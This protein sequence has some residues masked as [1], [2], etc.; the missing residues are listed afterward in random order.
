MTKIKG[1]LGFRDLHGFN[2]ALLG[3]HVSNFA[4]N[5]QSLV[6]RVYKARYFPNSHVLQA[7][8]G[9]ET[10]SF[11]RVYGKRKRLLKKVSDGC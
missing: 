9:G 11:G 1:G 7:R 5:P 6:A 4:S 8:R 10:I 2:L 3:K